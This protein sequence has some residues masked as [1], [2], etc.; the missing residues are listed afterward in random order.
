MGTTH[1]SNALSLY[2]L[3]SLIT[4]FLHI[5]NW[6]VIRADK[7]GD[8]GGGGR[9]GDDGFG[10]GGCSGGRPVRF[11]DELHRVHQRHLVQ[12]VCLLLRRLGDRRVLHRLA[13]RVRRG[14]D[15]PVVVPRLF[16][17]LRQ[18]WQRIFGVGGIGRLDHCDRLY[19]HCRRRL[20]LPVL[21]RL[22][23]LYRHCWHSGGTIGG[24][25]QQ[26]QR[27]QQ[28]Y[29]G[30]SGGGQV[31]VVVVIQLREDQD[32]EEEQEEG[33]EGQDHDFQ[34]HRSNFRSQANQPVRQTPPG[35]VVVG[36]IGLIRIIGVV[37]L[38]SLVRLDGQEG[39]PLK[40]YRKGPHHKRQRK[41]KK[42]NPKKRGGGPPKKKKKKKKKK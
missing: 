1:Y 12:L 16:Q 30:G 13:G 40:G 11:T 38:F 6:S 8:N 34:Q 24:G 5:D 9:N 20:P 21:L 2:F 23:L 17:R 39:P 26:Q 42:K 27:Q 41:K 28:R 7:P 19:H 4:D 36:L 33:K 29:A 3:R 22:P 18:L 25:G 14:G 10:V 15:Q 31:V 37:R 32:G 35:P